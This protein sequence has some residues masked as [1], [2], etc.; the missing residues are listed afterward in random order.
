[1]GGPLYSRGRSS[2]PSPSARMAR[3]RP[4]RKGPW[5]W[6]MRPLRRDRSCTQALRAQRVLAQ[7]PAGAGLDWPSLLQRWAQARWSRNA[8]VQARSRRNGTIFHAQGPLRWGRNLALRLGGERVLDLPRL[9]DG[10]PSP[11]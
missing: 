9:Y 10:P 11:G 8:W 3:L 6:K 7:A 4:Q 1:M 5:A 2:S